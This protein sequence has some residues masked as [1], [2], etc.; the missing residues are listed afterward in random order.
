MAL[1]ES[2]GQ[3]IIPQQVQQHLLQQGEHVVWT[4]CGQVE[5]LVHNLLE[6][7]LPHYEVT[8]AHR[9]P[10]TLSS[11]INPGPTITIIMSTPRLRSV[12]HTKMA[13]A[14]WLGMVEVMR[15]GGWKQES[16]PG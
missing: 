4:N 13:F 3:T 1:P 11:S 7:L 14:W 2:P 10:N 8:V 16:A 5:Q 6:L 9:R 15:A 12:T